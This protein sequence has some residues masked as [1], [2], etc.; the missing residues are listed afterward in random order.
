MD[1][2]TNVDDLND[3]DVDAICQFREEILQRNDDCEIAKYNTMHVLV[4]DH[5]DIESSVDDKCCSKQG[6]G[7]EYNKEDESWKN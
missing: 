1:S 5:V 3:D 6:K 2:L 7:E 4:D